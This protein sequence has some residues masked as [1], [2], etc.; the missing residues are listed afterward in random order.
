MGNAVERNPIAKFL[1]APK[2]DEQMNHSY[3]PPVPVCASE[4]GRP[5]NPNEGTNDLN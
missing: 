4:G 1:I 2:A 3:S 5:R